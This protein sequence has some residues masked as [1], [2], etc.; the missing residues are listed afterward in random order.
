MKLRGIP[1]PE[2]T[3][4]RQPCIGLCYL[5]KLSMEHG[6]PDAALDEDYDDDEEG[7]KDEEILQ[8]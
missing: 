8:S 5:E 1:D 7:N 3:T 6:G 4:K 2:V